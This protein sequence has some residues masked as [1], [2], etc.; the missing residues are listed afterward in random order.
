MCVPDGLYGNG[1]RTGLL[2]LPSRSRAREARVVHQL[3]I[4]TLVDLSVPALLSFYSADDRT[5][6]SC[7]GCVVAILGMPLTTLVARHDIVTVCTFL[8]FLLLLTAIHFF[9]G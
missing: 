6:V 1:H 2:A 3:G 8:P 7:L 5:R 4:Q 9:L